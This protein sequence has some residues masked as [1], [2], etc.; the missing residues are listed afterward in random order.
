L[1]SYVKLAIE[2]RWKPKAKVNNNMA[3]AKKSVAA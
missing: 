1:R 3:T 2:T